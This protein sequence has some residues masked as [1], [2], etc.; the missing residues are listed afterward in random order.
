MSKKILL[1][2]PQYERGY[3]HSARWDSLTISGSHWYPIFLAYCTGLLEKNGHE[4]M[5]IDAE[6]ENKTDEHVLQI[7]KQFVPEFTIIYV[8]QRGFQQNIKLAEHIKKQTGSKIVLVGPWCSMEPE[9]MLKEKV[10]DHLIDGEF[11]FEVLDIVQ[12]RQKRRYI[13]AK[14][15]TSEQLNKLPWVT[16]VYAKHLNIKKY[17]ISSLWYPFV[18]LFTGRRCY[19]GRCIFC[20]WPF[21]ILKDGGYIL[22]DINDVLDEIEWAA[23][24][25]PIKEIFIQD[26]TLSGARAKQL[27]EGIIKR[28]IKIQWSAYARGDLTMTP[29][30]LKL[31]KRSG[32]HCLHVGYESGNDELLEKMNKGVTTKT[33]E[34]FTRWVNEAKIDIHGD[35]MIGLPGET[36]ETARKT[37][38]WAKKLNVVTYQFA[39]PKPYMCTP[40]Y[41]W[42]KENNYL[43]AE[44]NPSLPNM[45][46]RRMVELC[47]QAM[48]ECYF[49]PMF[50]KRVALKPAEIKRLFMS[51]VHLLPYMFSKKSDLPEKK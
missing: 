11:E 49:N 14:R 1:I 28:G 37:I 10:V 34:T 4:C 18:D 46:Y 17:K 36:E 33:L 48:K 45:S 2:N 35:F 31:M 19:W 51:A 9:K 5:L 44:G 7:A 6:A 20:L 8:S 27:A 3:I 32:C 15:L 40:L 25:L 38:E 43:D 13:K 29:E 26:D 47:R 21:T 50:I 23:K 22:R 16:K 24:N 41:K 12:G 30:I 42:L 39:P